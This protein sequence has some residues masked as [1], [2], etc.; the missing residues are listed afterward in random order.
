MQTSPVAPAPIETPATPTS[1]RFVPPAVPHDSSLED[2][3]KGLAEFDSGLGDFINER[4]KVSDANDKL[5][6]QADFQKNN[7]QAFADAVAV[8]KIPAQ[9]SMAY[10][11]AYKEAQGQLA[12]QL[13]EQKFQAAYDTWDGKSNLNDPNAYSKF[14]QNFFAK[15]IGTDDPDVLRGLL[16]VAHQVAEN[17]LK[18]HIVNQHE[19]VVQGFSDTEGAVVNN[20][21][22]QAVAYANSSG[23]PVDPSYIAK[24]VADAYN[25]AIAIGVNP[26]QAQQD[27]VIQV[28]TAAL[29][30]KA[31]HGAE[32]LAALDIPLPGSGGVVLSS[33]PE[34][35]DQK[36]KV[37][38]SIDAYQRTSELQSA[39]L[40]TIQNKA[41]LG[42][43]EARVLD[44]L[45]KGQNPSEDDL[46]EGEK[47]DPTF[48]AKVL[49]WQ[50][51]TAKSAGT[52]DPQTLMNVRRDIMDGGGVDVVRQAMDR[53][54]IK[55][56]RDLDDLL[57]AVEEHS[58]AQ[59]VM[60][61]VYQSEA[62]RTIQASIKDKTIPPSWTS[63]FAPGGMSV[64]GL[65]L[66]YEVQKRME[67]WA[68]ANPGATYEQAQA[69]LAK[70]GA[71]VIKL[72]PEQKGADIVLPP[73]NPY[74]Q[75]TPAAP[76][77]QPQAPAAAPQTP[78]QAPGAPQPQPQPAGPAAPAQ[79]P[80]G[81]IQPQQPAPP[82]Q[83]APQRQGALT[84]GTPIPAQ[85]GHDPAVVQAWVNSLPTD[86]Q[87]NLQKEAQ[88]SG[89]QPWQI[90]DVAYTRMLNK[91]T[92]A[93]SPFG[94][95]PPNQ[96]PGPA[97]GFSASSAEQFGDAIAKWRQTDPDA[98]QKIHQFTAIL[99]GLHAALPYQGS[100]TLAAIKDNPQAAHILDFVA[101]PESGGN[102]NA[103]YGHANS[104][105]DLSGMT[106]S[107][108]LDFQQRL[109]TVDKL[110][111]SAVGRYQFMPATLQT[112]MK[113][114]HLSGSERFTPELQDQLALQLL[115]NRG[116][117]QWQSGKMSD[118]QFMNNLA[119]EWA[120]LPNPSTGRSQYDGGAGG[121]RA[122]VTPRQF[123]DAVTTAKGMSAAV[124]ER[125]ANSPESDEAADKDTTE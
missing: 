16:P 33:T 79:Q 60:A 21:I 69:Q 43:V 98:E 51:L 78:A 86:Q 107:Q 80:G 82:P 110:P 8:G 13:L 23:N 41:S 7:G 73:G 54:D 87:A 103:Y 64:Q 114:L 10:V 125:I 75:P 12:G 85:V 102:Y 106:L 49:Q 14:A 30:N 97:S 118:A 62:Y 91:S 123:N 44:G 2:L 55:N 50:D 31:H 119:Y 52:S 46:K 117:V 72:I 65:G 99:S 101:G 83:V 1:I 105:H 47:Y 58:K 100:L 113:Q 71:D 9:A 121:N 45:A 34:G 120:S 81:G 32:I 40:Q 76:A 92:P 67:E 66:Q 108:V 4:Q 88:R 109:I 59:Q 24:S 38:N 18:Q 77:Q 56:Q 115:K 84:G 6:A 35:A 90:A 116:L 93:S 48:R 28:T 42:V 17:G 20:A 95:L 22:A 112:L 5:L 74:G 15:N 27:A 124:A 25:K 37:Q 26:K 61:P 96:N 104:T 122:L 70:V 3:A 19:Q 111:S 53:G 29:L 94:S 11:Q 36:V 63:A 68:A 39:R 57:K 89:L